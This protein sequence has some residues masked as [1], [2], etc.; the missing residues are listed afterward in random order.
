MP[1]KAPN[2]N[3][4]TAAQVKRRLEITDT[5][6]YNHVRKGNLR[7]ITPPGYKQGFYLRNEVDRLAKEL[8]PFFEPEE[9][10]TTVDFTAAV[11]EDI[12]GCIAL[13]R[14]LFANPSHSTDDITLLKK[15]TNWIRKNP[16]IVYV[17]KRDK[18][19]VGIATALPFK[20]SSERFEEILRGDI[21][22][23]LGDVDISPEDIEEYKA[24]NHVQ[25]YLAEIGIRP[26]LNKNLR[27][28]YGG[29]L[30]VK[31][32]DAIV[33]LGKR[34]VIIEKILAV[35]STRSGTRILQHFG[36]NEVA[37]SRPDT[38]LFTINI[39]E[40]ETPIAHAYREALDEWRQHKTDSKVDSK[41]SEQQATT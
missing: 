33:N 16:E 8:R 18:E 17:L 38:R 9:E 30:I 5:Q 29:K 22:I 39:K 3:Y 7:H 23:L 32:T 21:S 6:L 13:N 40:S 36:F 26:S 35:G 14:E 24:E 12:T 15:W 37:F 2:A 34:G 27:R 31:F 20:P 4:Y 11:V 10:T 41:D 25:L 1:R 28:K 19:I